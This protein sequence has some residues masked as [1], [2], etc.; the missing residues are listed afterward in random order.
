MC[1]VFWIMWIGGWVHWN[2]TWSA[3]SVIMNN[4]VAS[5]STV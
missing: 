3:K 5:G 2:L 1:V 4:G